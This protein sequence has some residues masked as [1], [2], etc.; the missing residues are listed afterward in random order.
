MK[1]KVLAVT[2]GVAMLACALTACGGSSKESESKEDTSLVDLQEAGIMKVGMCPEYPPFES[3][4]E[5]G[6]IEGFDV[7]LANAIG[8][9]L[10]VKLE[11]VN[12]P[13]EGLIAGLENGDFDIIMSG[14]SPEEADGADQILCV[15]ENYYAVDEVILTKDTSIKS[16]EDLEGKKVGSHSGSTSEYAVQSLEEEGIHVTSAPYNRHSEAFADLQNGNIDAQV[17]EGTW[18][19]EKVSDGD[20]IF[21]VKE[22]INTINVAGVIGNGKKAFTDAFNKALDELKD[23]GQYDEIVGKWFS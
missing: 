20:E 6:D 18:A 13:Y 5:S 19:N 1:K 17:V 2:L 11:F 12:T 9:K 16:K 10:G 3:I 22:P 15:T 4:N 8:E 21:I 23:S 14:M 7:D